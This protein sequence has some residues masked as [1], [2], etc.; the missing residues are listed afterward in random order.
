V[1]LETIVKKEKVVH[2]RIYQAIFFF[3]NN[4]RRYGALRAPSYS[5]C[6]GLLEAAFGCNF[7]TFGSNLF[8]VYLTNFSDKYFF[9]KNISGQ[10]YFLRKNIFGQKYFFVEDT[11]RAKIFFW[12]RYFSGKNIFL[13]KILFGQKYFFGETIFRA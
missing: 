11:F 10:K 4:T 8:V 13:V 2:K 6:R 3:F 12:R 5:S 9:S 1:G 7:R